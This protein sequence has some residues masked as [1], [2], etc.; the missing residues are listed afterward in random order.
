MNY[1]NLCISS[2][3]SRQ[4][5]K[6]QKACTVISK[7][8]VSSAETTLPRWKPTDGRKLPARLAKWPPTTFPRTCTKPILSRH[9][10][11]CKHEWMN[12]L[13]LTQ[14]LD[15]VV[16]H[17]TALPV[18]VAPLEELDEALLV[19]QLVRRPELVPVLHN[20]YLRVVSCKAI[21]YS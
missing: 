12:F 21:K 3:E 17:D 14:A 19:P 5:D 7:P 1:R 18:E 15:N 6:E 4:P 11:P 10:P 16:V 9:K 8:L 13:G 2:F 20:L